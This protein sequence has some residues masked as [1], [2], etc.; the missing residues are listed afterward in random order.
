MSQWQD[1]YE[2]QEGEVCGH[3]IEYAEATEWSTLETMK[4]MEQR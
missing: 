4:S 1:D 2:E 3:L